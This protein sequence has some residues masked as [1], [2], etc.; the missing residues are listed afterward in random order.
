MKVTQVR[1]EQDVYGTTGTGTPT[2]PAGGDLDGSF[3]APTV[4]A[5]QGVPVCD[6]APNVGDTFIFDG[7]QWCP[8]NPSA[9]VSGGMVP[10]Y[11]APGDTFTVPLYKQ[12]PF[13]EPIEVDGALV[14][15]GV[16]VGV[17]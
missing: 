6:D 11:I 4:V 16:L 15:L 13:A 7:T 9:S 17:D 14:V 10:Y 2:G 5:I 3:P 12:A 1:P 8:D